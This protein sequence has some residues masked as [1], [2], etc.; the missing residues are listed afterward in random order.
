MSSERISVDRKALWK[1]ISYLYKD[2]AEDY[3]CRDPKKRQDHIFAA[4]LTLEKDFEA[5]PLTVC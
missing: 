2:E 3:E 1:V 4:V 5:D